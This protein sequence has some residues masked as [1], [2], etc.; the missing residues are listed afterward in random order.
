ML[1][2]PL[3][4]E[5]RLPLLYRPAERKKQRVRQSLSATS[6]LV[7]EKVSSGKPA[8]F[9]ATRTL[10]LEGAAKESPCTWST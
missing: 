8:V 3:L 10:I 5:P 6:R 9:C 4:P 2:R 7:Q 1:I